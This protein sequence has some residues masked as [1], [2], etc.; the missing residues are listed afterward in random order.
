[1]SE[2]GPG[3]ID[4]HA[5]ASVFKAFLREREFDILSC[6]LPPLTYLNSA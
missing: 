2:C 3:D 4:P 5:V 1:M 6:M